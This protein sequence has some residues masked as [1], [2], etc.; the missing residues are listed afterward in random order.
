MTLTAIESRSSPD[1]RETRTRSRWGW[2]LAR[3][4]TII[5]VGLVLYRLV[6]LLAM[7]ELDTALLNSQ[8]I[9]DWEQAIGIF[10]EV[11]LQSLVIGNDA[12][13]WVLNRYYFF[14]H[15]LGMAILLTWLYV[16]QY[17]Y[18]G[19]VR[20]VLFTST[21]AALIIHVSFPLAPPRWFPQH[22]FA[23]TL[24]IY[25]PKIY[26]SETI[27][28]TANQ[29]AAMPSLHVGWA[30]IAGWA[31]TAST[32]SRWRW[33]GY[34]HP[35]AMTLAVVVTANHWWLDVVGAVALVYVAIL[36]DR[37]IQRRLERRK[38]QHLA[39]LAETA[40]HSSITS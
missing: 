24:Q 23:D 28:N 38:Q 10:N 15:F 14:G 19:R 8:R 2:P 36:A 12:L 11:G 3:E 31:I 13:I 35:I 5:A 30:L 7:D 40:S 1:P 6:R 33:L 26:D 18:Y 16:A 4:I 34:A 17:D 37:P 39:E 25:G 32:K 9:V 27:A 21:V 22:G 29:I 20:R